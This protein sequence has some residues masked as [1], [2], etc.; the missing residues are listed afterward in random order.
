MKD[1]QRFYR[2]HPILTVLAAIFLAG[3]LL[4]L[5][6][7]LLPPRNPRTAWGLRQYSSRYVTMRDGVALAVRVAL[8]R[9]PGKALKVP[10]IMESSRYINEYKPAFLLRLALN[11]GLEG[12][13]KNYVAR[14][15]DAGYAYVAVDARGS[16]ASFGKRP[17]E[18]SREEVADL[19]EL[20]D[21]IAAQSW[22]DGAV[23]TFGVS[24]SADTAELAASSGR[25]ALKAVAL[26]YP[27]FDPIAHNAMPGG[28][29]N[30]PLMRGWT[31]SNADM[32]SGGPRNAFLDGVA[33]V[34][35]DRGGKLLARA[36]AG[37]ETFDASA[38]LSR[39][40]YVDDELAPG[41]VGRSLSPLAYKASIEAS[42][43]PLYVR[44]G[45]MD[46][47]TAYGALERF[48]SFSNPQELVLGPWGHAGWTFY[49]PYI[50]SGAG[51]AELDSAQSA[52]VIAFF[53]RRM[54]AAAP[55]GAAARPAKKLRY[56]VFGSGEW[57]QTDTWS[58]PGGRTERLYLREGGALSPEPPS[59]SSGSD[60]YKVDFSASTGPSNRW[61]TNFGGGRVRYADRA[62]EDARLLTYAGEA[63][64]RDIE[65]V[66]SPVATLEVS[67]SEG[68]GA[69]YAYLED[70]APDG[71]S[72]YITEGQLRALHRRV[73]PPEAGLEALGPRHSLERADGQDLKPGEIAEIRIAM[74]PTAVVIR[75]GHRLRLAIAGHDASTFHRY[76]EAGDPE[77]RVYRN[78]ADRSFIE[79]PARPR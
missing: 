30:E 62:S 23:G 14:F 41:Y 74:Q 8:P 64:E 25:P 57:R 33:P 9:I 76:P 68:D 27:D 32:D 1:S 71:S 59:G 38:A 79:V 54:K 4:I 5:A 15:L 20:V 45:W 46:S 28:I 48:Q 21:W 58:A 77:L 22:S 47:A 24:Y 50:E 49:D 63:L 66:G 73:A 35:G 61:H 60:A 55:S 19:G 12:R 51:I 26:L 43:V 37:H 65:I 13:V 17:M 72:T 29:F 78:G 31:E 11:L 67:S 75:A 56:Y 36:L 18:L 53:D 7:G 3:I 69:F 16:G 34:D 42:G 6:L 70:L 44:V 10:A 52:E 2:R 40:T 39:M